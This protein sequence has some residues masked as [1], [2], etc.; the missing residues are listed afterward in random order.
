MGNSPAAHRRARLASSDRHEHT[1][2]RELR[3]RRPGNPAR[4]AQ[5]LHRQ[6]AQH[7]G[8]ARR[9]ATVTRLADFTHETRKARVHD[10]TRLCRN[11][12]YHRDVML[13]SSEASVFPTPYE[14]QILRL[15]LRMTLRHGLLP[16]EVEMT[17]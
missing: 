12:T 3:R 17:N 5:S 7:G 8:L 15:R 4:S 2:E 10:L 1:G 11:A 13:S 14:K 6:P 9:R 16:E